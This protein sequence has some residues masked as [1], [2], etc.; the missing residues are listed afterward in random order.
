M[1]VDLAGSERVKRAHASTYHHRA[2]R[3]L[4]SK[5][6]NLSLSA[7]GNCISA[8]ASKKNHVPFRD[9]KLT[10]LLQDSLGGNAKTSLVLTLSPELSSAHQT[11]A[12][13]QFGARASAVEVAARVHEDV[14][15]KVLYLRLQSQLDAKDSRIHNLE[16]AA[17]KNTAELDALKGANKELEIANELAAS[18]AKKMGEK[19]IESLRTAA[20]NDA[21]KEEEESVFQLTACDGDDS[22]DDVSNVFVAQL[23]AL[24]EDSRATIK[25]VRDQ[26]AKE[27]RDAMSRADAANE[28]WDRIEYELQEEKQEHLES[29]RKLREKQ[30]QLVE[31]ETSM[32]ERIGDLLDQLSERDERVEFLETR[33]IGAFTE[34]KDLVEKIGVLTKR[35]AHLQ[36]I[37]DESHEQQDKAL[38]LME[39]LAQRV[40]L[41]EKAAE[42]RKAKPPLR[43]PSS[44]YSKSKT[45]VGAETAAGRRG[46]SR[47]PRQSPK[48]K[49]MGASVDRMDKVM[50]RWERNPAQKNNSRAS[51]MKSTHSRRRQA[52]SVSPTRARTTRAKPKRRSM[53]PTT[54]RRAFGAN[55]RG[56]KKPTG[57]MLRAKR[58]EEKKAARTQARQQKGGVSTVILNPL[59]DDVVVKGTGA[60]ASNNGASRNE[61]KTRQH[62]R[63][64]PAYDAHGRRV[65][66]RSWM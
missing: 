16:L 61:R 66:K 19:L 6:I 9:A 33:L 22:Q 41:L 65:V 59:L 24:K 54:R 44:L 60:G 21:K 56:R 25:R 17:R 49:R 14:D 47:A 55:V 50:A 29:L 48:R 35:A 13:L 64:E 34:R 4:E 37:V 57:S 15:Y 2:P 28:E 7:L 12:T 62:A 53:S 20:S 46:R 1:I 32:G 63:A 31:L 36:T 8:L 5:A 42:M 40:E 3:F 39:T 51:Y 27:K 26:C 11:L 18:E 45:R 38:S 43:G 58:R 52:P 30:S 23:E 10:R